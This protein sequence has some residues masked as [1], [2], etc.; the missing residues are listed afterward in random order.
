M[1]KRL[2]EG[3]FEHPDRDIKELTTLFLIVVFVSCPF[4]ILFIPACFLAVTIYLIV[5]LGEMIA[6]S[7][8][9]LTTLFSVM[10]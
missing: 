2:F 5:T 10:F 6:A 3:W 8:E 9:I 1:F 7:W 4:L